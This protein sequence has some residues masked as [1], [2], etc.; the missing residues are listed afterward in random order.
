MLGLIQWQYALALGLAALAVV[1][2]VVVLI[3]PEKF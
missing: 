3:F 1:Y 2:L